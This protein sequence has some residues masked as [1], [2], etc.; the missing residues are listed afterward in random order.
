[1]SCGLEK[2]AAGR[3]TSDAAHL[4]APFECPSPA[5]GMVDVMLV[6]MVHVL[7][8]CLR[9]SAGRGGGMLAFSATRLPRLV[10]PYDLTTQR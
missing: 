9:M 10:G 7:W 3:Q 5:G 8:L 1:M 2:D 6:C 4:A